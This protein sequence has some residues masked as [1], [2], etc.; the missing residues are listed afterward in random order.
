MNTV[1]RF[2]DDMADFYHLIFQDWDASILRQAKILDGIFEKCNI[3]KLDA[4]LDCACGIGTQTLG[5]AR[6]GY[7]ITCSDISEGEIERAK[8][9]SA[10]RKLDI[11]YFVADFCNLS[12]VFKGKFD[13]IIA[14]DNALPHLTEPEQLKRAASSIY[15]RLDAGGVF[16][17]SI[18]DYDVILKDKPRNPEPYIL[19]LP[20]GKRVAFQIWDWDDDVYDLT[21]YIVEDTDDLKIH[22]FTSVYRAI[23]R[24]ELTSVFNAAGFRDIKWLMPENSGFYQPIMIA[25]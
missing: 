9:E 11:D 24:T 17:A 21:Q 5:F 7:R 25:K 1:I 13:V 14:M 10:K 3:K 4:I 18:R 23:T 22:K 12:A 6:L 15:A 16:V 2:Y 8:K 20:N 19:N